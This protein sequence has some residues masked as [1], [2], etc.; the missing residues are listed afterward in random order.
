MKVHF[1]LG[2]KEGDYIL[3]SQDYDF[4]HPTRPDMRINVAFSELNEP[5]IPDDKKFKEFEDSIST[6]VFK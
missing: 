1:I 5:G 2:E 3:K 6:L 4:I